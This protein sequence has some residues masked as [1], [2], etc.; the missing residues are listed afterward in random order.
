MNRL[1]FKVLIKHSYLF[2]LVLK[3]LQ[4]YKKTCTI[5]ISAVVYCIYVIAVDLSEVIVGVRHLVTRIGFIRG[6][7]VEL[8]MVWQRVL[9]V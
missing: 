4:N 9:G 8:Q 6:E 2:R 3:Y 5:I 7:R 1:F